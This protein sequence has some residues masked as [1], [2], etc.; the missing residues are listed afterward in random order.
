MVIK[1]RD[2][3]EQD[4][5]EDKI[6]SFPNGIFAFEDEH[7]FIMLSPLGDDVYPA[8]LQSV[9]NENLC[10]I[11]FD[12]CQIV[13]DYSVTADEESLAAAQFGK[14]SQPHYLTLAVV[15]E[16]YKDTTVNLKS[17][18]LVNSEKMLA[19]Q[20]IAAENYPIKFPIFKKAEVPQT[21]KPFKEG[22]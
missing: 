8:W 3:G 22:N 4:V 20:T 10:F 13:S 6:I 17:P 2:F 11:V 9:D 21:E 16:D 7:R 18:I 19:A 5:S 1:T 15:P 12:P 14:D